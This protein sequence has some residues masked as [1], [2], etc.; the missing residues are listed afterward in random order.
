MFTFLFYLKFVSHRLKTCRPNPFTELNVLKK[1][2]EI[3]SQI[4]VHPKCVSTQK[5]NVASYNCKSIVTMIAIIDGN[6]VESWKYEMKMLY[7]DFWPRT[8]YETEPT[9]PIYCTKMWFK[10]EFPWL[11]EKN[12]CRWNAGGVCVCVEIESDVRAG[13][14]LSFFSLACAQL[15]LFHLHS[16]TDLFHIENGIHYG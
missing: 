7:F 9:L 11:I 2:V 3:Y 13:F 4:A 10:I 15:W 16:H 12:S 1:I 14:S 5:K 8:H 6:W